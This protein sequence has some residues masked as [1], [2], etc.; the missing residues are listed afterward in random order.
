M[1]KQYNK[2]VL[3]A[4]YTAQLYL[5]NNLILQIYNSW[6]NL[7]GNDLH[8]YIDDANKFSNVRKDII[9]CKK[10]TDAEISQIRV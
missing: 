7:V 9:M 8:R 3:K 6:R 1:G 2:D 10:L 5:N 4:H